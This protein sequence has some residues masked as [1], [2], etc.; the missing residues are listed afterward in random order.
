MNLNRYVN[1]GFV[2]AAILVWIMASAA[3]AFVFE[4]VAMDWNVPLIGVNF[5]VSDLMGL[6]TGAIVGIVLRRS[7]R[8]FTLAVEIAAELKKVTWPTWKEV[9]VS[10]IVVIITTLVVA[11][12]LGVFDLIWS[13]ATK[14][15]YTV[16]GIEFWSIVKLAVV[17]VPAVLVFYW[18]SREQS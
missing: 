2:A 14:D 8:I 11:A 5:A 6:L 13:W 15:L 12:I 4:A 17:A 1:M 3:Y 10:T 9:R 7:S 18:A 16:S